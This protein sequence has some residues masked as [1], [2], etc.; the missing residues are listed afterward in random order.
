[1]ASVIWPVTT[2]DTRLFDLMPRRIYHW[3][4]TIALDAICVCPFARSLIVS[5]EDIIM[6]NIMSLSLICDSFLQHGA[7]GDST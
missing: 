6:K 1:M 2:L 4:R 3:S 7:Q 5:G